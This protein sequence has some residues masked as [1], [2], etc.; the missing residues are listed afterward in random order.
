MIVKV[1][2][3]TLTTYNKSVVMNETSV[4]GVDGTDLVSLSDIWDSFKDWFDRVS[5]KV[6][7]AEVDFFISIITGTL[8]WIIT[9]CIHLL[10]TY[11]INIIMGAVLWCGFSC[12]IA[13]LF[14]GRSGEWVGRTAFVLIVG[15]IWRI[16]I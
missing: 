9:S 8:K 13:P 10:N 4:Q 2:G 6:V 14:G 12:M 5:D 3:N 15:S 1:N 7:H 16:I 11:S